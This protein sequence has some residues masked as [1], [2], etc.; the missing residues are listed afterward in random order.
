[1][2]SFREIQGPCRCF[3]QGLSDGD[4]LKLDVEGKDLHLPVEAKQEERKR[5]GWW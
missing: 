1:M 2:K 3:Q 4:A 5:V